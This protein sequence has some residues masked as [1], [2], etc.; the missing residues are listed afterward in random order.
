MISLC[1]AAC[2]TTFIFAVYHRDL[3]DFDLFA[4]MMMLVITSISAAALSYSLINLLDETFYDKDKFYISI[5][6]LA[7]FSV[8]MARLIIRGPS[9]LRDISIY[10]YIAAHLANCLTHI[11]LFR[12]VFKKSLA[13]LEDYYDEEEMHRL[14]WV[15]FCYMIMMLT[16]VFILV[17]IGLYL[18][19]PKYSMGVYALW[20]CL[21]M[22]YFTSNY[23]SFLSSHKILLDA[24]AHEA[25]SGSDV[26]PKK[27]PTKAEEANQE[28][29]TQEGEAREKAFRTI[30]RNLEK[31]VA[32]GMYREY[33]KSR[34]EIAAQ[35]KTSKEMLQLYFAVKMGID[36]R[37]W[38]TNL[39]V[40][41][42]KK[43]LLEDKLASI[44]MI[45]DMAGFSDRSN[46][47]RQ[48]TKIVGCSPKE[49]RETDGHPEQLKKS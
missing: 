25:L 33:D 28:A 38:R 20:Y 39:R 8:V 42:A 7:I 41:D 24:F 46:F 5:S 23:I 2:A 15:R 43:M 29:L 45:S 4:S 34:E 35:I 10:V 40:E 22:L 6:V 36:F 3:P 30:E 26:R 19:Q 32:S 37:T 18:A 1:F 9:L 14:R 17:Y 13:K 27:K 31:W 49:W 11:L 12:K 44:Q 48:F 21:F 16:E 47:H